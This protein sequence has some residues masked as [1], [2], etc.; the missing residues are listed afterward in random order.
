MK[1]ILIVEDHSSI[2]ENISEILELKGYRTW[3]AKNG[4]AGL[5]MA[6]EKQPDIILCDVLMPEMD[7]YH[8]F[9]SLKGSPETMNIPFIFVTGS[10]SKE[11]IE[12]GLAAGADA[13]ITKPFDGDELCATIERLLKTENPYL[14]KPDRELNAAIL[15][16]T[17][18]IRS[19]YPELLK[20][21]NEMP[22]TI[23]G[24]ANTEISKKA[25]SDYYDSLV[26]LVKDYAL[27]HQPAAK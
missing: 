7:G 18:K 27:S 14:F 23:P 2:R 4:K 5:S 6:K 19:D 20:Y 8:V 25:L 22:V 17:M 9:R 12:S 3:V 13:Y 10:A 1:T 26:A 11:D 21:M 16:I 24:T 15:K